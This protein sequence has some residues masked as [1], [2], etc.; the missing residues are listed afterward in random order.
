MNIEQIQSLSESLIRFGFSPA[1]ENQLVYHACLRQKEFTIRERRAFG[2]DIVSYSIV[3]KT[4]DSGSGLVCAYYDASLRKEIRVERVNLNGV[5]VGKVEEKMRGVN[6]QQMSRFESY[7]K[8][9]FEDKTTWD[10]L[11][12]AESAIC[13]LEALSVTAEGKEIADSLRYLYWADLPLE[14]HI[15]NLL[16]LKNRLELS[17]RFYVLGQDG[18]TAD[19]AFR[20]LNNRWIQRQMQ[21]GRRSSAASEGNVIQVKKAEAGSARRKG[22]KKGTGR[23]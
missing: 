15:P 20:F 6:W 2:T 18:I 12:T 10:N 23:E 21:N 7:P 9:S 19:E 8:L 17:Q 16:F 3:C 1:V 11:M 4:K 13:D 5:N 14:F 22:D